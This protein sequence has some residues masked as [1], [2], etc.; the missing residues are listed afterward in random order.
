M[1]YVP[2]HEEDGFLKKLDITPTDIEP[3]ADR[4]T[5]VRTLYLMKKCPFWLI[6]LNNEF[7][8]WR[9][10]PAHR[11][12]F[13]TRRPNPTARLTGQR[14]PVNGTKERTLTC[15]RNGSSEIGVSNATK[16]NSCSRV[17]LYVCVR[18]CEHVC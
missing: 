14:R 18:V 17:D 7:I 13:G 10:W 3:K 11:F 9:G 1:P 8:P 5:Q 2:G 15:F 6:N 4:C 12:S 16:L